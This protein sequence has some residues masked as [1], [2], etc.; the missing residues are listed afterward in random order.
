MVPLLSLQSPNYL[1]VVRARV[2]SSPTLTSAF[3]IPLFL[4]FPGYSVPL[5]SFLLFL[6]AVVSVPR[7]SAA[8]VNSKPGQMLP[9]MLGQWLIH[10]RNSVSCV[11]KLGHSM[12]SRRARQSLGFLYSVPLCTALSSVYARVCENMIPFHGVRKVRSQLVDPVKMFSTR[13]KMRIGSRRCGGCGWKFEIRLLHAARLLRRP[14]GRLEKQ[15]P[16]PR[17]EPVQRLSH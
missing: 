6:F 9:K 2:L 16:R 17:V 13:R 1:P 8:I 3:P 4:V 10:Y 7:P 5:T 15:P 11:S 12:L 14:S